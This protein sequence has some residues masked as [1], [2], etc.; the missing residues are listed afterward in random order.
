MRSALVPYVNTFTERACVYGYRSMQRGP[1]RARRRAHRSRC[2]ER[3]LCVR[4]GRTLVSG[5]H[6]VSRPSREGSPRPLRPRCAVPP[7]THPPHARASRP[8]RRGALAGTGLGRARLC[9]SARHHLRSRPGL[10]P[11]GPD[12]RRRAGHGHALQPRPERGLCGRSRDAAAGRRRRPGVPRVAMV[13]HARAYARSRF[14][15]ARGR[16]DA[17]RGGCLHHDRQRLLHGTPRRTSR[18]CRPGAPTTYDWGAARQ[19]VE[20]LVRRHGKPIRWRHEEPIP[21]A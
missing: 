20:A 3:L 14:A 6:R 1:R 18:V 8:C 5:R 21:P 13:A 7:A 2:C 12:G 10:S 17:D 15:L 4:T 16:S 11:A 9:A 19:S